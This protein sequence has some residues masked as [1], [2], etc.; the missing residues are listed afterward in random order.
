VPRV[1][2]AGAPADCVAN[3]GLDR[4]AA[5]RVTYG[6]SGF[7]ALRDLYVMDEFDSHDHDLEPPDAGEGHAGTKTILRA[8]I[9]EGLVTTVLWSPQL[10]NYGPLTSL[11]RSR[12][13][14]AVAIADIH[15]LEE[16]GAEFEAVVEFMAAGPA[17]AAA[18]RILSRWAKDVGYTRIWFPDGPV[19]LPSPPP[20]P[21]TATGTCPTCGVEFIDSTPAFWS[22]VR[23]QGHFPSRCV[24]CG[25]GLPQWTVRA[26]DATR[27]RGS[28]RGSSV[29]STTKDP[30]HRRSARRPVG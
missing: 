4:P 11:L 27:C 12:E 23:A 25:N 20:Q 14:D 7:A 24:V 9:T 21:R 3:A 28:I 13:H 6:P 30:T 2:D 22:Q 10:A 15:V 19:D 29:R 1:S 16:Q 17:R 26:G 8:T 18:Q 5:R